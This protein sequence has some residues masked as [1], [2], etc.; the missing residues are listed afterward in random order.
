MSDWSS[1]V[2]S[3]DL[4]SRGGG[5]AE[6]RRLAARPVCVDRSDRNRAAPRQVKVWPHFDQ[7]TRALQDQGHIVAM[8][9]PPS[10]VHEARKNAPTALLLAPL[11]LGSFATLTGLAALVICNDSG[12]SHLSAANNARSEEHTSELQS[13][14]RISYAVFCLK[15]NTK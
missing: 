15:N 1:D 7:L 3:S 10:E 5:R 11:S 13:L 9:P 8:C 4:T 12:V 6:R 2:C 14:M